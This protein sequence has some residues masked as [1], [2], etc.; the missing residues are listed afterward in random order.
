MMTIGAE[1]KRG[2]NLPTAMM[3]GAMMMMYAGYPFQGT[4]QYLHAMVDIALHV[5]LAAIVPYS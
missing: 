5:E 1:K 3:D 2:K 4:L